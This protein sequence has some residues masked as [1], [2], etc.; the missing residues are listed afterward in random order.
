MSLYGWAAM[1]GRL[2]DPKDTAK[3]Y[4]HRESNQRFATFRLLARRCNN[5]AAPLLFV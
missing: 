3:C 4:L 1:T 5:G 2:L